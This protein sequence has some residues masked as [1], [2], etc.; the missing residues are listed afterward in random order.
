MNVKRFI[1][2]DMQDA[3]NKIKNEYGSDAV[4]LNSRNIRKRGI[5]GFFSKPLVEVMVG[6]EPRE[7]RLSKKSISKNAPAVKNNNPENDKLEKLE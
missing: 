2:E 5:K 4:I 6:Y 7:S 3:M 1:A